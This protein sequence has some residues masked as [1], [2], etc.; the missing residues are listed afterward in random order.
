LA[1][2]LASPLLA[3][4]LIGKEFSLS[5]QTAEVNRPRVVFYPDGRF[6]ASF[7]T[8]DASGTGVWVRRFSSLGVPL[9]SEILVSQGVNAGNDSV[10][11]ALARPV[12]RQDGGFWTLWY[13]IRPDLCRTPTAGLGGAN[14]FR[15]FSAD[16]S[17]LTPASRLGEDCEFRIQQALAPS[18]DR[19][20]ILGEKSQGSLSEPFFPAVGEFDAATGATLREFA[21]DQPQPAVSTLALF[22]ES[23]DSLFAAWQTATGET[24]TSAV[25]GR[26]FTREGSP[27][28]PPLVFNRRDQPAWANPAVARDGQGNFIAVWQAQDRNGPYEDIYAQRISATGAKIGGIFV[29]NTVRESAQRFPTVAADRFGNFVIVWQSFDPAQGTSGWHLQGQLFRQD[30]RRAGKEFVVPNPGGDNDTWNPQVVFGPNGTFLL[31]YVATGPVMIRRY[32]ASPGDE[33]CVWRGNTVQCDT[34]RTGGEAELPLALP[35]FPDDVPLLGDVDGD[36]RADPCVRRGR[37]FLC[38]T[39]HDGTLDWQVS[40]GQGG[41]GE[42]PLLGDVDGDG[43]AEAC[44]WNGRQ[45][46]CDTAHNGGKAEWAVKLGKPGD[47]PLLADVDGDGRADPCVFRAGQFLCDTA[48]NGTIGWKETF[49]APGDLPLLGDFDGDGRVDACVFRSGVFLSDTAH[50]G[51]ATPPAR[52]VF[53]R[54]GDRPLLGNLDGL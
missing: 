45:F 14:F 18:A 49:G 5:S 23:T 52:L 46:Q 13:E 6:L 16:G 43:R 31:H 30:G 40:F 36:G 34:G 29:V 12:V 39:K 17:S 53:G 11:V 3:Q 44:T 27:L 33:P 8:N 7:D 24:S 26:R 10:L 4:T 51:G 47:V 38:D 37:K 2:A 1:S 28:S 19:L 9:G 21:V 50:D 32:A 15:S 25:W 48:H 42:I 20:L 41:P 35:L 22:L 54:P